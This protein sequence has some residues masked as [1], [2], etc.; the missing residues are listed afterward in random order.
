MA[1]PSGIRSCANGNEISRTGNKRN[2]IASAS[3]ANDTYAANDPLNAEVTTT[4][5]N[6]SAE[7][8][9]VTTPSSGYDGTASVIAAPTHSAFVRQN[10]QM[11]TNLVQLLMRPCG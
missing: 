10:A 9:P 1:S 3:S 7:A 8:N 5:S 11:Y 2:E 4:S 6:G